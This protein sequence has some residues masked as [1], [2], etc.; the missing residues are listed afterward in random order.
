MQNSIRVAIKEFFP[1]G[2]TTRTHKSAAVTVL[3][4]SYA[5]AFNHWLSAF[6]REAQILTSIKHMSGV[7]KLLDFFQ[8]NNTAY[9]VMDFLEGVSLRKYLNMRGGRVKLQEALNIMRPVLDS[10]LVLHQY[11]IIHKDI[12]PENIIVVQNK[13]VKLID[14]GAA[15]IFTQNVIKP[16]IMLKGGYSPIELYNNSL[17]QGPWSDIY[18]A[19]ATLYNCITGAIPPEAPARIPV[20]DLVRP[21]AFG[22]PIPLVV[23]NCLMRSMAIDPAARYDNMGKYI[24][25]LYGE[26]LPKPPKQH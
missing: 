1:K 13:Y 22:I 11:G 24:Q 21:S 20:D 12:S 17:Q 9:I 7:V 6:V 5:A 4:G 15:S 8:K 3:K 2:Y 10:L 25:L 26:F 19:G 23:E 16:F 14:F 18:Q